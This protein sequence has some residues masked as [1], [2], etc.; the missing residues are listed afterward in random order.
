MSGGLG[1]WLL[2]VQNL[3]AATPRVSPSF[4]DVVPARPRS[5]VESQQ[6]FAFSPAP[7][8]FLPPPCATHPERVVRPFSHASSQLAAVLPQFLVPL[9]WAPVLPEGCLLAAP[10]GVAYFTPA[11]SPPFVP[12]RADWLP[13]FPHAAGAQRFHASQQVATPDFLFIPDEN[14][15]LAWMATFPELVHA[16][17]YPVV[18]QGSF[19]LY[20]WPFPNSIGPYGATATAVVVFADVGGASPEFSSEDSSPAYSDAAPPAFPLAA[21]GQ[22][23]PAVVASS[24]PVGFSNV[25]TAP[26]PET[27]P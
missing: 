14:G 9:D 20:P 8:C 11:V 5:F 21:V 15:D 26:K 1:S 12:V 2:L 13:G 18:A 17:G 10:R 4:P 19:A 24:E 22:T 7:E 16:R 23:P 25:S 27:K 6:A 3:A